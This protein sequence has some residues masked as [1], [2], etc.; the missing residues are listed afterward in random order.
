MNAFCLNLSDVLDCLCEFYFFC[1]KYFS[2]SKSSP[3]PGIFAIK[4]Y[5]PPSRLNEVR[6][7][8]KILSVMYFL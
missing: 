2:I 1:T 3:E 7:L 6:M 8:F 4:S 5:V